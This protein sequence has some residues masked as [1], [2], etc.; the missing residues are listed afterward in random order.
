VLRLLSI[1]AFLRADIQP[2]AQWRFF[3]QR[4]NLVHDLI[5]CHQTDGETTATRP[6]TSGYFNPGT[7]TP[8]PPKDEPPRPVWRSAL[9]CAIGFVDEGLQLFDQ[10]TP[11]Q[12]RLAAGFVLGSANRRVFINA[13]L[14]GVVNA[15]DDQGL[16][17][18]LSINASAAS[19][20]RHSCPG[21][22]D[23][24]PSNRFC[25]R[26]NKERNSAARL[27]LS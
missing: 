7:S 23:V 16:D 10:Q 25:H 2:N 6:N 19:S 24:A 9:L 8:V 1:A 18:P 4:L 3:W 21:M 5:V 12:I 17:F 22:K 26:G 13:I 27:S 11:I 15:D 14:S 20:T